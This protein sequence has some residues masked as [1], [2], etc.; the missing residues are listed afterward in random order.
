MF[1]GR[2]LFA[3]VDET[4]YDEFKFGLGEPRQA[5]IYDMISVLVDG[6]IYDL[7]I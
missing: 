4:T 3:V 6:Q 1:V 2:N 7:V 5:D